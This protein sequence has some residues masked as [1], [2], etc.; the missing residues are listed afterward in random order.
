MARTIDEKILAAT[1]ALLG[2]ETL[3]DPQRNLLTFLASKGG[4]GLPAMD[5]VKECA[6][7]GGVAATPKI[8]R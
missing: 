1:R 2:I 5:V 7:I 3:P 8:K 6:F 4:R